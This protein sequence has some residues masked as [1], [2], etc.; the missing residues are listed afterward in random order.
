V[1]AAPLPPLIVHHARGWCARLAGLLARPALHKG[2]AFVL[3]PCRGVHTCFMPYAIDVVFVDR[4][5][6]VLNVV[7]DMLPWRVATC[8]G[9]HA[10]IELRAGQASLYGLARGA[11]VPEATL[12]G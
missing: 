7:A 2:E 4:D 8:R 11:R 3:A 10:A 1:T 6:L 12:G 5:G 9:A